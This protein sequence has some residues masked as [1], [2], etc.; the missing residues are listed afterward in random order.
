MPKALVALEGSA[1]NMVVATKKGKALRH[2]HPQPRIAHH[3]FR[4]HDKKRGWHWR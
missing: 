2:R 4:L 1:G 3:I